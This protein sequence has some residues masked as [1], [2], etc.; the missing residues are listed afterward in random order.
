M[1][2]DDVERLWRS[3]HNVPP[4]AEL[5]AQRGQLVRRLRRQYR[6][7][8]ICVGAAMAGL[9]LLGVRFARYLAGGGAFDLGREWAA[10]A[11]VLL[12]VLGAVVFVR[13]YLRHRARHANYQSSISASLRALLDEN[14]LA[15]R[16]LKGIALLNG[17]MVLLFPVI[18]WQLQAVGKARPGEVWSML[19]LFAGLMVFVGLCLAYEYHRRLQPRRR[20]LEALLQAYDEG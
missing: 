2:F 15:R 7:F 18:A 17:I 19:A 16:R 12:P 1:S 6:G 9:V 5:D 8:V 20:E 4:P 3:S 10:L 11:L 13:Q 14:R